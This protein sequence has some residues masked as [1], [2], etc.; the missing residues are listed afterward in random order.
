MNDRSGTRRAFCRDLA[1]GGLGLLAFSSCSVWT[2]RFL[3][4]KPILK[5]PENADE[6]ADFWEFF[7]EPTFN[8][9]AAVK[10]LN[11]NGNPQE[12]NQGPD[13]VWTTYPKQNELIS[14]V[15]IDTHKGEIDELYI[16]YVRPFPVSFGRLDYLFGEP[17][18]YG[19]PVGYLSGASTLAFQ[20]LANRGPNSPRGPYFMSFGYSAKHQL[21]DGRLVKGR[22]TV[23]ADGDY[24]TDSGGMRNVQMIEYTKYF[25]QDT[26]G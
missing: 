24:K 9:D 23:S 6:I 12:M 14:S 17:R 15:R 22:I 13:S 11:I 8:A 18:N 7:A 3:R 5:Y 19:G 25:S 4:G 1:F 2:P 10:G 20:A 21:S 16:D 26:D